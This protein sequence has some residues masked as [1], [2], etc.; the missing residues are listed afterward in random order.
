MNTQHVDLDVGGA[1]GD[2][3]RRRAHGLHGG[4]AIR[5][6][7]REG[8]VRSGR[9]VGEDLGVGAGGSGN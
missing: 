6:R 5:I 1:A 4:G 2:P 3:R 9:R 8:R 7:P